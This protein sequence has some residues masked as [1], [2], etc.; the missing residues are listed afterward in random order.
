[1]NMML[2]ITLQSLR[3]T[4]GEGVPLDRAIN[5]CPKKNPQLA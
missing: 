5:I 1:M 4:F 2:L 3:I